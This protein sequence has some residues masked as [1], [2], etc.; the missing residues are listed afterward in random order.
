MLWAKV[1]WPIYPL[2][3]LRSLSP[4]LLAALIC[5]SL[6]SHSCGEGHKQGQFTELPVACSSQPL[7]PKS[8]PH[9]QPPSLTLW[10]S[11]VLCTVLQVAY[12]GLWLC[13][14][15]ASYSHG[16]VTFQPLTVSGYRSLLLQGMQRL[17]LLQSRFSS[18]EE[19]H[20]YSPAEHP[21]QWGIQR[22]YRRRWGQSR[23]GE[24]IGPKV[25]YSHKR[26]RPAAQTTSQVCLQGISAQTWPLLSRT[27]G[28]WF[29]K[30]YSELGNRRDE[31]SGSQGC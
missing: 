6:S 9:C 29:Q 1:W 3:S 11:L 20:D 31:E 4:L 2:Y 23:P 21:G 30:S 12:A 27:E 17:C 22:S 16:K 24:L 26:L 15:P 5:R 10:P 19:L 25:K 8:E 7:S 13:W 14:T 28:I 18:A